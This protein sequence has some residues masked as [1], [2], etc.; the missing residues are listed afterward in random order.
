ME[1]TSNLALPYILPSQAQKHVTHN[2][3]LRRLDALV[4]L[5]VVSRATGT[6]PASPA[7]GDRYIVGASGTGAWV[8]KEALV[9]AWQDGAW[10]FFEPAAGWI[11]AILDEDAVCFF[12]GTSWLKLQA[13]LDGVLDGTSIQNAPLAGIGTAADGTNNFAAK[14][15]NALWTS[16][17]TDE[18]GTGDLRYV[19][20]K[21]A[22]TNTLSL[23]MQSAYSGRAELGLAGS[24]DFS[25]KVSADGAS[26]RN[27]LM[28]NKT[29]GV[30]RLPCN[31]ILS[32]YSL[33]LYADSGRFAG[34]GVNAVSVGTFTFPG[35]LTRYNSTTVAGLAKFLTN[36]TDYGG[37]AGTL[38]ASVKALVDMIRDA[39]Y[40]RY[41]S[42]YWIA[43][44]THGSGTG[45]SLS[46][47]SQTYYLSLLSTQYLRAPNMTFHAYFRAIDDDILI[48]YTAGQTLTLNGTAYLSHVL[49]PPSAGWVSLTIHDSVPSRQSTAYTPTTLNL[50]TKTAGTRYQ[51]ACPALIGGIT[52]V[53]DNVG[54]VAATNGWPS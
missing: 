39:S 40:R 32:D 12:D 13:A 4:Q 37:S 46:H 29:T 18:G 42:E 34:S 22:S 25:L 2:E 54:I 51:M 17:S 43:E 24:D 44:F 8:G 31:N 19:M 21:Q 3:A 49:I 35:Y 30:V 53:D 16:R 7:E 38:N 50:F 41:G 23:L 52:T 33:N 6:P 28:V 26:W 20:N 10:A 48:K 11:A 47:L 45:S 14:L 5:A 27:A 15:N 36:N 9:A 1:E